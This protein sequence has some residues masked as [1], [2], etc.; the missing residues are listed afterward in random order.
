MRGSSGLCVLSGMEPNVGVTS[1]K[2][3]DHA[4][5]ERLSRRINICTHCD[6][7]QLPLALNHLDVTQKQGSSKM[8]NSLKIM[9][10]E[11]KGIK[12][13][14]RNYPIANN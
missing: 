3:M 13:S 12:S 7:D 1:G 9:A 10:Q 6:A 11:E 2:I 5:I 4:L 8:M 14:S